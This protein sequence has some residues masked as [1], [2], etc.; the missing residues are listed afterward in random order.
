MEK[1]LPYVWD[2]AI[3][4]DEFDL[5]L[6]GKL[7]RGRLDRR[8]ARTRLFDYAPYEEIVRR[9][10]YAGIVEAWPESRIKLRSESRRRGIDFLVQW[11]TTQHPELLVAATPRRSP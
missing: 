9:L 6:A 3:S 5:L 10:G 8:W 11:L 7:S 1:K 4:E 2:Y